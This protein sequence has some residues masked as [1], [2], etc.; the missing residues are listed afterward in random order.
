MAWY[1]TAVFYHI[2]PLGLCGCPHENPGP[3]APVNTSGECFAKLDAWAA[4]AAA[5]GCTAIYL[6][7]LFEAG[8]H[9]YDTI[10]YRTV[11]RRLGTNEELRQ[12]VANCHARGQRVVLDGV[13]NHV[14][15]GFAPFQDLLANREGSRWRD[16]FSGV[17]FWGNNEYGDGLSYDNWGGY[18]LL[19]K[20]NL[21]NP[22]VRDYHFETVRYWVEQFDIDGLRLD[23]ADV[24]DFDFM[25]GLRQLADT[26]KPEFWLLGEVIHGD[27][28]RWANGGMLHSVTNYE[29]HKGLWSGHNDHNYFEIAHSVRR[30]LGLCGSVKLYT[31]TDNHDVPRLVNRLK[32]REHARLVAMLAYTLPGVPSLYYGSEF[33]IEGEK[34]P[35]SDWPLRPALEL[36]DYAGAET[37]NPLTALYARLGRLKAEHPALSAGA[38]QELS[39]TTRQYAFARVGEGET[40]ITLLNNDDAPARVECPLPAGG[41]TVC[42]ALAGCPGQPQIELRLENGRL[43]AQLPA[44]GGAV[45]LVR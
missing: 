42:D 11:D 6:G 2:Y 41:Q 9:G 18:N 45:A 4:H 29:L 30:L 10:D 44:G 14:G 19:V 16:W 27:Y 7:P 34:A 36:A 20:L 3:D 24:L 31:F 25:R 1:D 15:R 21:R 32:N 39:L 5:L 28:S 37:E 23:A 40:L 12:F 26:V 33:G 8:S 38:Y 13:F 22:E 35:G 17:N 43:T